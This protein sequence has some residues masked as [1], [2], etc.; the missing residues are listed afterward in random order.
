MNDQKQIAI[1]LISSTFRERLEYF[2]DREDYQTSDAIY[3]EFI[4][5]SVDPENSDYIWCFI[6]NLTSQL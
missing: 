1:D 6:P 2:V 5:G 3:K 4:V